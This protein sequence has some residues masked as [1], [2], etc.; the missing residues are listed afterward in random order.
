METKQRKVLIAD[1]DLNICKALK[2]TLRDRYRVDSTI[3]PQN[4][5]ELHAQNR[6]DLLIMDTE[7]PYP[8][9]YQI[10]EELRKQDS[11]LIIIGMSSEAGYGKQW[12]DAGANCFYH[13][14]IS[15]LRKDIE[16]LIKQYLSQ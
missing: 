2:R 16:S 4:V 15:T 11:H 12:I 7:M 8:V 13:K 14:N 6:Y 1:D 3:H 10:C 9:G 5:V